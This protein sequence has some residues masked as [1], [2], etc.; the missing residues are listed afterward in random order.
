MKAVYDMMGSQVQYITTSFLREY[1][2]VLKFLSLYEST[3]IYIYD[4][5]RN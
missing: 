3:I 2:R 1:Q 5:V 4:I